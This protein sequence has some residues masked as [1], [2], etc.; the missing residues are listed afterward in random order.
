MPSHL[1][2]IHNIALAPNFILVSILSLIP[3]LRIPKRIETSFLNVLM[4]VIPSYLKTAPLFFHFPN[5]LPRNLM[6]NSN[7]QIYVWKT[8]IAFHITQKCYSSFMASLMNFL[9]P[10]IL[11][12]IFSPLFQTN[13]PLFPLRTLTLLLLGYTAH[14]RNHKQIPT[15]PYAVSSL[16]LQRGL[17]FTS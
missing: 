7:A 5:P 2:S 14:I 6:L 10:L 13:G 12:S 17:C 8:Y 11:T 9:P 15:H 3:A 1:F 4:D 16:E